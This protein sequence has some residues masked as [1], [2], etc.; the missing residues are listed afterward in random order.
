LDL[1]GLE[2]IRG[3]SQGRQSRYRASYGADPIAVGLDNSLLGIVPVDGCRRWG[4]RDGARAQEG[5]VGVHERVLW[6]R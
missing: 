1:G 5:G 3:I 6:A 4:Q 2:R